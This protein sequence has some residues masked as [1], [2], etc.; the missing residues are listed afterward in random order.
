VFELLL[1]SKKAT[2]MA[3]TITKAEFRTAHR[4]REMDRP[5]PAVNFSIS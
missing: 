5:P 2:M 3:P 1:T 4:M